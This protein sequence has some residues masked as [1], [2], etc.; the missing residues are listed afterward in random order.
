MESLKV[1][2]LSKNYKTF[3][4]DDVSFTLEKGYIMGFIGSNSSGKTT[5]IKSMLNFINRDSGTVLINGY[6]LD[7]QEA[8]LKQSIGYVSSSETYYSGTKIKSIKNMTKKFYREWNEQKYQ[9][10]IKEFGIDENKKI[11][12]LST[13][14]IIKFQLAVAMS[15]N[16]PLLILD[17]P[18]SN[19]D[20]LSRD[21]ITA[22]FQDYV[23]DGEHSVLFST[24]I[25]SDLEKCADYITYIKNGKIIEST[26]I[27]SFKQKYLLVS[28]SKESLTSFN[29][30]LIIGIHDYEFGFEG[31]INTADKDSFNGLQITIP[32]LE[33]IMIHCER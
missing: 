24:H 14:A 8:E 17:E 19:I 25:T 5:T 15:H 27:V 16:A 4:L 33:D 22:L 7:T 13:G 10:L 26:D 2:N 20:P 32:T 31:M 29:K 11:K 18:T 12:D 3:K 6:D 28:G 1:R 21:K 30:E 9:D 23:S